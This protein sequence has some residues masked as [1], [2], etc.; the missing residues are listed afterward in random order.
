MIKS[1]VELTKVLCDQAENSG[2]ARAAII[3]IIGHDGNVSKTEFGFNKKDPNSS[4]EI[5]T[6]EALI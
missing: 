1:P 5:F 2:F 6:F 3:V 4:P